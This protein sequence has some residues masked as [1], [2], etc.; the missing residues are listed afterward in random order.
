MK[1]VFECGQRGQGRFCHRCANEQ[2]AA[3][4]P[5]ASRVECEL[6]LVTPRPEPRPRKERTVRDQAESERLRA[7]KVAA[8]NASVDLSAAQSQPVVLERALDLL[9]Q[10]AAGAHP[11]SLGGKKL[12]N[13]GEIFSVPVGMRH[14]ILVEGDTFTPTTFVT[15]EAYNRLV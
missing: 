10:L 1:R 9:T 4:G 13:L 7:L 5:P 14:R 3:L 15:H 11:H 2:K 12:H 6:E 8:A